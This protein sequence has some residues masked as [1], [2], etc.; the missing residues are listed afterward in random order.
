MLITLKCLIFIKKNI[1]K[2]IKLLNFESLKI[3]FLVHS[4]EASWPFNKSDGSTKVKNH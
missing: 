1:V 3:Q 2:V 4:K